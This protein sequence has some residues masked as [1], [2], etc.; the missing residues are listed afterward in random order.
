MLDM[1]LHRILRLPYKLHIHLRRGSKQ[2]SNVVVFLHGMGHSGATWAEVIDQLPNSVRSMSID[3][4]GYGDSPKPQKMK[5]NIT[6]QARSLMSTL[7]QA[8][9]HQ[10][11]TLVGHSM[12]SLVAIEFAKRYPLFV[13]S[14]VLCSPPLYDQEAHDEILP[15]RTTLLKR[16][17]R[18]IIKDPR[19]VV[20]AVPLAT[21]LKFVS[22]TFDVNDKNIGIY[23]ATLESSIMQ[24]H[25][26][27][28]AKRLRLP[29]VIIHGLLDP[30]VI[31]KNL[32]QIVKLNNKAKIV[33]VPASHELM[34]AYIPAVVDAIR[35]QLE[36]R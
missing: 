9:V 23:A 28:D 20:N 4:L 17:F 34:G 5:Y 12:G 27:D 14:L 31:R 10:K 1:F 8:G 11:I 33:V 6:I 24:Q 22:E 25:S 15:S 35:Y 3:L 7:L 13:N 19:V 36:L 16:L 30:L 2:S 29:I 21:K 32:D 26:L 18:L